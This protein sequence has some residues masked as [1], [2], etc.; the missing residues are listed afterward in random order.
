MVKPHKLKAVKIF[1]ILL[2]FVQWNF[3]TYMIPATDFWGYCFFFVLFS[4]FFLDWKL[5]AI[6]AAEIGISLAASWFIK[7]GEAL[8]VKNDL[9]VLNMVCRVICIVLG[10]SLI[11]IFVYLVGRFLVNAKK[12]EMERNNERV[13][14]VLSTVREISEQ[15]ISA[16]SALSDISANEAAS[17]EQLSSTSS[18]LLSNS[19]VLLEKARTGVENLNELKDSGMQLSEN[20]RKVGDNSDEVMKKSSANEELL[21]SLR[22][23]YLDGGDKQR[24]AEAFGGG[25]GHKQY[26][27]ADKRYCNADKYSFAQCH[28]RGCPCGRSRKGIQR[29][30]A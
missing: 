17:A 9:F 28:N 13:Q 24:C 10:L 14:T 7:G 6:A 12:D 20:V 27:E 22:F 26:P 1:V 23:H 2:L 3:I 5:T 19:N 8:P 4:G 30:C 25:R 18:E 11:V 16:G 21:N 15:F 29:C